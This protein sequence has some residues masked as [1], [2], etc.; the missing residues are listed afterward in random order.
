MQ[1]VFQMLLADISHKT[2]SKKKRTMLTEEML[3]AP[4]E[5]RKKWQELIEHEKRFK[6]MKEIVC[7]LLYPQTKIGDIMDAGPLCHCHSCV[8][9]PVFVIT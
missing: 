2:V 4:A 7:I 6:R 3:A 8:C 5:E 9:F 1:V